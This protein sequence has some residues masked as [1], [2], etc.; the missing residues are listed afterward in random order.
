M[1]AVVYNTK[2]RLA[3]DRPWTLSERAGCVAWLIA[4]LLLA[5]ISGCGGSQRERMEVSGKVTLDGV[6]LDQGL[7]SFRDAAGELPTSEVSIVA[8]DYHIP[9]EK[10]L[11][12]GLYRVAIDSADPNG[13]TASPTQYSMSIPVSRIPLK[14]N[15]ESVLKAKV[16]EAGD[17]RFDFALE[18]GS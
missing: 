15:G 16:T 13:A 1:F 4:G 8:G 3:A 11:M 10:G 12:P 9:S 18:S 2:G 7:I 14:Y 5:G 17:N 6:P